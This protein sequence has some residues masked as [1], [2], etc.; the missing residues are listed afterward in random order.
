MRRRSRKER[1][2]EVGVGREQGFVTDVHRVV[3]L[4]RW[5]PIGPNIRI[6]QVLGRGGYRTLHSRVQWGESTVA[7]VH[8]LRSQAYP[9]G[10]YFCNLDIMM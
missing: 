2:G 5:V 8:V 6:T 10:L 3:Q 9:N 7:T 1:A 4:F